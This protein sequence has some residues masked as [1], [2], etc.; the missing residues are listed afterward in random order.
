M[1]KLM[2]Q[3]TIKQKNYWEENEREKRN[4]M[5]KMNTSNEINKFLSPPG[6]Q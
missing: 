2:N 1:K 4:K 6:I 5:F 3:K